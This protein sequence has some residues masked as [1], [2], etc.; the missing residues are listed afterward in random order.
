MIKLLRN[1]V[2]KQYEPFNKFIFYWTAFNNIYVTVAEMNGHKASLIYD[3]GVPKTCSIDGF[4]ISKVKN[5]KEKDQ[6]KHIFYDFSKELKI[7]LI[8]HES[9]EYFVYRTP[10][11]NS[12]KIACDAFGQKLNGVINV[13]YTVDSNYPVW[14]PINTIL[15]EQYMGKH[16]ERSMNILAEQMLWVL[17][18]IRN[19]TFHG[20]KRFDDANDRD[21]VTKAVPLLEMI[22]M[23]YVDA[24]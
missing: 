6:L 5:I 16:D 19:N 17:Y 11:W 14:S 1:I 9:T 2:L 23:N 8:R 13:G 12:K 7:G 10:S 3:N 4:K 22:V 15:Y 18:T 20:G 24:V 21:V